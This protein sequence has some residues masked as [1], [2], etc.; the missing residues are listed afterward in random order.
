MKLYN[1]KVIQSRVIK[2]KHYSTPTNKTKGII[3]I[4]PRYI[5]C[6]VTI[7]IHLKKADS[8]SCD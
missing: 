8:N 4:E 1:R 7:I 6:N 3:Y 2:R 5:G